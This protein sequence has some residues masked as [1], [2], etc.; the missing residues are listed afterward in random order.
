MLNRLFLC[1]VPA[2]I[3]GKLHSTVNAALQS[4]A[5]T[6]QLLAQGAEPIVNTPDELSKFL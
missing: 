1:V 4:P 6:E 2:P 3:I 5:V